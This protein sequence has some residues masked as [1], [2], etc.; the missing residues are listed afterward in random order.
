MH[1]ELVKLNA[2]L[3]V[4]DDLLISRVK[5]SDIDYQQVNRM[6]ADYGYDCYVLDENNK[7]EVV[8]WGAGKQTEALLSNERFNSLYNVAYLVD[9][10]PSKIGTQMDGYDIFSPEVL[11]Q[12]NKKVLISAVQNSVLIKRK[13]LELGLKMEDLVKDM[14]I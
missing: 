12:D 9:N 6:L 11:M 7:K 2:P 1:G 13:F 5:R 3:V 4:L 8:I 10:T 14:I